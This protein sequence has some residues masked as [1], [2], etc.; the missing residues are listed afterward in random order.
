M[1]LTFFK[2]I[3]GNVFYI[4]A[5]NVH[6]WF[7]SLRNVTRR[8]FA[9]TKQNAVPFFRTVSRLQQRTANH[10]GRPIYADVVSNDVIERR[11]TGRRLAEFSDVRIPFTLALRCVAVRLRCAMMET[12]S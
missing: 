1:F 11:R 2:I 4:Y 12:S 6:G 5:P 9:A 3:F 8:K 10:S 7:P